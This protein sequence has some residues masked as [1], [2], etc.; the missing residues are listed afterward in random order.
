MSYEV[1]ARK[2]RPQLFDEVVGQAH[3]TETLRNAIRSKRVA[4]AYVFVGPRGVGKTSIARI[5]AKALNCQSGRG[6]DPCD[7]CDACREIRDG[8]NLDVIEIDGASNNG[9]DQVRD[10]RENVR[11]LPSRGPYKIYIIDEVHMLSIGAFNAL[12]KTLEEPPEHVKF[13]FATTEVQ[14][15]PATILSR[16]QRFDL[17]RI[18]TRDISAHLAKLA[19]Q[20]EVKVDEDALL[21][22]ARGA[23]GGLRD[24]ESALDQLIAFR[25][26]DIQEA[27]VLAVFGLV[28]R[29]VLDTMARAILAGDLPTLLQQVG[30]LDAAGKDLQRLA[31]ELLE[32]FRNLLVAASGSL[33][34]AAPDTTAAQATTLQELVASTTV[35]RLLSVADILLELQSQ[36]RFALSRRTLLELTLMRC[37]RAASTAS[38]DDVLAQLERAKSALGSLPPGSAPAPTLAPAPAP[39]PVR[40]PAPAAAA[41]PAAAVP[42]PPGDELQLV[43]THWRAL[44]ER[45]GQM[46]PLAKGYLMDAK[47]VQVSATRVTLGFDPEFAS[48]AQKINIGR[49]VQ[50]IQKAL[51]E[52]LGR[53]VSVD[54]TVLDA[55]AA[56]SLPA[57]HKPAARA[58]A[59]PR[60]AAS[61]PAPANA[62]GNPSAERARSRQAWV[63]DAAVKRTLETFHGDILDIRE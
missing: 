36:I 11:Y 49:N 17:R 24:A 33:A 52:K 15:I 48:N 40:S 5:F 21:A 55:A 56:A 4:H 10:L 2:W 30:D 7:Q 20:E 39:A 61:V 27:D 44:V 42:A 19:T 38:L 23:E 35:P 32:Y 45:I 60:P 12:L 57:D 29:Q 41:P 34:L 58:T 31:Q 16:C 13:F 51:E 62:E 14:K 3:V 1:L 28:S 59:S 8:C 26:K 18:A 53:Q 50:A 22:I 6:P 43:Q 37:A 63:E 46:A 54:F 25:G 9:V 47:P